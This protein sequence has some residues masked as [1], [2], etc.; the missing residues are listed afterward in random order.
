MT[1]KLVA[2]NLVLLIAVV[3]LGVE[4]RREW[5]SA[6]AR[7]QAILRKTI[8]P[9]PAQAL[10]PFAKPSPLLASSYAAIADRNLFSQDRN[11]N[12]IVDP[13]PPIEEKPIPAFPVAR[14]VMLWEGVPPTVVLSDKS[15]GAQR[16]YHPGEK[17]GE[18]TIVSVDNQYVVFEWDGKQFKKRLDELLDKTALLTPEAPASS[19][20]PPSGPTTLTTSAPS[21]NSLST[22]R[23]EGPGT[24]IGSG[25]K[26]CVAGDTAPAGTVVDGM[27]KVVSTTP[28]GSVC[29]WESVK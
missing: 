6:K 24:D 7:E 15:G 12:V 1:R 3:L 18:W 20:A 17:I 28:F 4:I 19:A 23:P 25:V 9:T 11:S 5:Q 16:G 29:R 26:G 8:K 22:N 21:V 27:R 2:L 13:P 10:T 14:G